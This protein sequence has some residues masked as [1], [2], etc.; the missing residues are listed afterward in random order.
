MAREYTRI[1]LMDNPDHVSIWRKDNLERYR[2]QGKRSSKIQRL[3]RY[4]LTESEY[5]DLLTQQNNVCAICKNDKKHKN[6]WHVDHCH[7]TGKVR[8]VLCHH[9]NNALGQA[10]E[11]IER[12]YLM[13]EYLKRHNGE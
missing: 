12:L 13:I 10:K 3:K 11:S 2:A 8:G 1:Y 4:N 9:C 7:K 5:H 6:D